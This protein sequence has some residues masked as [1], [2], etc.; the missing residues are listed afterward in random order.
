[1]PRTVA[2]SHFKLSGSNGFVSHIFFFFVLP[3]YFNDFNST[4]PVIIHHL[5]FISTIVAALQNAYASRNLNAVLPLNTRTHND[6]TCYIHVCGVRSCGTNQHTW[7]GRIYPINITDTQRS[8]H[9]V[10]STQ[11]IP[12]VDVRSITKLNLRQ[13]IEWD[14]CPCHV[15]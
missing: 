9:K 13:Y 7:N 11:Y 4:W 8:A 15:N 12:A 1:M 6:N 5:I 14:R 10:H 3:H 2:S